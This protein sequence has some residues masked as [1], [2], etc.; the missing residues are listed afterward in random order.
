MRVKAITRIVISLAALIN[1]VLTAK[2]INPIPFNEELVTE[3][4]SYLFAAVMAI[5]TWW[6]DAPMTKEACEGTGYTKLL[7]LQKKG[8][9]G[10]NFEDEI[11]DG[12]DWEEEDKYNA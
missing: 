8:A 3:V 6:K 2:G 5:W 9:A 11:E 12:E 1:A 7:K 10:E 4:I